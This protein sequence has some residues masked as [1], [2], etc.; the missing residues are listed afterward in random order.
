MALYHCKNLNIFF[1]KI[2]LIVKAS[3]FYFSGET[4]RTISDSKATTATVG[5]VVHAAADGLAL[6]AA[7]ASEVSSRKFVFHDP[8][9]SLLKYISKHSSLQIIVFL[10]I[11]LHKAPASFGLVSFLLSKNVE[12]H[13]IKK[14]LAIFAGAAPFTGTFAFSL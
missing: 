3:I 4:E 1:Y 14:N 2:I 13:K 7:G 8:R 12:R 9:E 6:G 5:L 11:M 10:A